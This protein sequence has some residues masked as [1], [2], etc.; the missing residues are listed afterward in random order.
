MVT[1]LNV[2]DLVCRYESELNGSPVIDRLS[3]T[4][5]ENEIGCLV[6][7]S[8]CGKTTALRAI[9]GFQKVDE[10]QITL[11]DQQLSSTQHHVPPEQRRV[12]IVF[13]DYALFPH[14]TVCENITFGINHL[15]KAQQHRLCTEL[16][17]LV[18]LTHLD[19][20][21]P[22]ELSGGQQQRVALA[23]ALAPSP[24]LLLLD[25]P[26]SS[27]DTD[28]RRSLALELRDI[29][30]AR[31]ICA[32]MV[33]HDQEEAFAFADKVGVLHNGRLQQWDI[34]YSL[35]H[36]PQS[37][38]VANF[39]G[40]GVFIPGTVSSTNTIETE[41]GSLNTARPLAYPRSSQVEVLLRPDDVVLDSN[42]TYSAKITRKVFT[43]TSTL[44]TLKLHTGSTI[45]AALPSHHNFDCGHEINIKLDA[46]HVIAFERP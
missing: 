32:I 25:E 31:S 46:D 38:Y 41:V 30:K 5:K 6:G 16:L 10:G 42:P 15:S 7:S 36:E 24:K 27:L 1:A 44:Y 17:G 28:L 33:T 20:R 43:G 23:R 39:I 9:A 45:E 40:Q 2:Q 14:L 12:G 29:L 21:Y 13:Q 8:G 11:F 3:F 34:P 18:K 22:H 19:H 37:R 35:Y 26:L 4:L